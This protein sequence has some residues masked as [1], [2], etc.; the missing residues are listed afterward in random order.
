MPRPPHVLC[1][2]PRFPATYWGLEHALPILGARSILP[3]LGLLTVTAHLPRDWPVRLCDLNVRALDERELA[4]A[5]VVLISGML[6]QRDS[7]LEVAARARSLGKPVVAGGAYVSTSPDEVQPHVDCV[8]QGEAEELMPALVEALAGA[9]RLPSR[10]QARERPDV[11]RTPVPRWDL[12]DPRAYQ[13]IGVQFS[14]GCPFNCEF[15]DIIEIFGR[16]PRVKTVPQLLA[17]LDAIY[18]TGFRGALFVV[19]DNFIGNK[20]EV[21]RLLPPLAA[22]MRAHGDPFLLYTEASLN[23]ASDGALVDAMVEAGFQWVFVGIE[24]PSPE[25]LRHTQKLQNTTVDAL[26]G[27]R[28]LTARGL[29]V[30]AGFI[31]GFDTDDEQAVDRQ[32]DWI[33]SAPIPLAMVSLLAALPGTQLE[34]RLKREGRLRARSS[35]ELQGRTN[36]VT[37]LDEATLLLGYARLLAEIYSPRAYFDR[38]LRTLAL[39]PVEKSRFRARA[40]QVLGWLLRSLW[41]QGV[42]APY[43][44]E[45][46][47]YLARVLRACP[48]R[49]PRAVGLAVLGEHMIR[50]TAEDVLP[51]LTEAITSALTDGPRAAIEP[52]P[53]SEPES[54]PAAQPPIDPALLVR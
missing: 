7:M 21:R 15:C 30:M 9:R 38:A 20:A 12:I 10:M 41:Q 1:V 34:R 4:W 36:F 40:G 24:T 54:E 3:P 2:W 5:D 39:C 11:T 19:D 48:R 17:E 26:G 49:L 27:V 37:R 32:R 47:H 50:Y 6:I 53:E 22:W 51:R 35:G 18:A 16:H 52:E 33:G 44:A 23:L 28:T 46:W 43:R 13:S 45:Y 8:V 14:R 31:V 25:A 42:R 29:E